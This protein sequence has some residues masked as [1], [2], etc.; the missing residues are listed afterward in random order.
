MAFSENLHLLA[1]VSNTN[2]PTLKSK[3]II[4]ADTRTW[5]YFFFC[6]FSVVSQNNLFPGKSSLNLT[7][8]LFIQSKKGKYTFTT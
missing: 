2:F 1:S 7:L 4:F 8:R 6:P 3:G 5:D